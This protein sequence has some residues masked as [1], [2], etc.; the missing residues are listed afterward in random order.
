LLTAP[1][2]GTIPAW[3]AKDVNPSQGL[4][5]NTRASSGV[6]NQHRLG[7][8]LVVVQV[9]I[10]LVLMIGAGLLTRTLANLRDFYPG[11]NQEN[12]LLFSV[13]PTIIGY[14]E[15]VPLYELLNRIEA[16]PGVR[17]VSLSVNEPM[18]TNVSETSV[19]IQGSV[20]RQGEDLAPVNV[21]PVGPDCFRTME[22][23]VLGGRDFSPLTRSHSLA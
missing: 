18:S 3:R 2:F 17:S 21:E 5:Q 19:T 23:P 22:T 14:K 10:S 13:N 15:A 8:S 16:L 9:A 6:G 7:K 20:P 4:A 11:F 1:I 12:V